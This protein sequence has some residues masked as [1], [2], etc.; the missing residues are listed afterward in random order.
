MTF[1]Y[2]TSADYLVYATLQP[3]LRA[4]SVILAHRVLGGNATSALRVLVQ[5]GWSQSEAWRMIEEWP[6]ANVEE[7]DCDLEPSIWHFARAAVRLHG[8]RVLERPWR[9]L[10]CE[11]L[12]G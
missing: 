6:S 7:D 9:A 1:A 4:L 10:L 11:A 12:G 3:A 2:T 5:L 8:D